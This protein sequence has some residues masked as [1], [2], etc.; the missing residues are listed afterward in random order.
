MLQNDHSKASLISVTIYSYKFLV[1]RTFNVYSLTNFK[2]DDWWYWALFSVPIDC[3]SSLDKI[4]F[5]SSAR[6]RNRIV[7]CHWVLY[8]PWIFSINTLSVIWFENI[9]FYLEYYIFIT[10]VAFFAIQNIFN[11][12]EFHLLIF[13]FVAFLVMSDPK[14]TT[15]TDVKKL[16]IFVFF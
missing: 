12:R 16:I 13:A 5:R 4:L 14:N 3:T 2:Y 10:L 6:F 11:L 9:F 1:I 8:F 15:K 7:F